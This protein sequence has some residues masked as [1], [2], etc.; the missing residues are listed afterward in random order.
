MRQPDRLAV[1][2]VRPSDATEANTAS[3]GSADEKNASDS[4]D[5]AKTTEDESRER[6]RGARRRSQ[7][8]DA[9]DDG[10]DERRQADHGEQQLSAKPIGRSEPVLI[11]IRS[12]RRVQRQKLG[13]IAHDRNVD[14]RPAYRTARRKPNRLQAD[15][16]RADDILVVCVADEPRL[17]ARARSLSSAAE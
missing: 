8:R 13:P 15:R 4:D 11:S 12:A 5:N 10:G 1:A 9:N 14:T 16:G 3:D 7:L 6:R 2:I 17:D